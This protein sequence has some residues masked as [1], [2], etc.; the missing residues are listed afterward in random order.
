ME[1]FEQLLTCAICL[2][3]YRNPKLLP[4][5]HSFCMEPCLEGLVDY[6]RRQVKCPECRAEHRIPYQGVQGFPTSVTL[7]RFLELHIEITGELP[8]PNSGQ[9]MERCNVCSE[10]AYCSFCFHCDK[11]ICEECKGAHK[12]ILRREISRINNQIRRGM[13]RLQ[14]TLS[15]V[16][17]NTQNIQINCLSV[18]EEVEEIYRRLSKAIKDRTEYLRGELDRYLGTE[19]KSLTSLKDNLELEISN[20]L[21]NCDLADKYMTENVSWDDCELMDCKEIF[22]KT[23]EFIRNFEYETADYSRKV[24]LVLTHDP[25]QLVLNV[26]GYGDLNI[27]NTHASPFSQGSH[28]QPPGGTPGLMRSKSDHRLASQFR[29]QDERGGYDRGYGDGN[30]DLPLGGRKFGERQKQQQAVDRYGGYGSGR[31]GGDYGGDDYENESSRPVRSRYRSRFNRHQ[32]GDNDSDNEVSGRGVRFL[33]QQ[34]KERERV[35]DT[36]DVARG[37]LSGITRLADSPRVMQ[38]LQDISSG[39]K[40]EKETPTPATPAAQPPQTQNQSKTVP[41]RPPPPAN[42][43]VSEDDEIS[44]IKKQNKGATTS[45]TTVEQ[46]LPRTQPPSQPQ[47]PIAANE[48]ASVKREESEETRQS[49][50]KTPPAP[51]ATSSAEESDDESVSSLQQQKKTT[52]TPAIAPARRTSAATE[53]AAHKKRSTS[54]ESNSSTESS[55]SSNAFRNQRGAVVFRRRLG[56]L[57]IFLICM[58]I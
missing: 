49:T 27:A 39:K 48:R 10:K 57:L 41:K 51:E 35:L 40:R 38:K 29:Q 2:D 43:Q 54:T 12:D 3:R 7:Q 20:I 44:K 13:H 42:R 50:R 52:K 34:H 55:A 9:I 17:K 15:L 26:A 11:K 32:A 16:E 45:T 22:L 53:S 31:G 56:V 30:E 25:N 14:D 47:P 37:P 36:E 18:T 23:V 19:L 6:V 4:C 1:Q 33:E 5:Q 28:L 8:D 58:C 21:S 24:R 46:E